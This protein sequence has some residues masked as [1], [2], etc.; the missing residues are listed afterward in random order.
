MAE[1]CCTAP[2]AERAPLKDELQSQ[3]QDPRIV[4]GVGLQ[5]SIGA[6]RVGKTADG[7]YAARRSGAAPQVTELSVIEDVEGF[8]AELQSDALVNGKVLEQRHIEVSGVRIGQPISAHI[9]EGQ[10]AR[11]QENIGVVLERTESCSGRRA[12]NS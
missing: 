5:E 3:L 7:A 2:A 4:R 9:A 10:P 1:S 6:Q 11:F 8:S 12:G